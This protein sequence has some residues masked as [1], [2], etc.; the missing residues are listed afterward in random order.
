MSTTSRPR[1]SCPKHRA[2]APRHAAPAKPSYLGRFV[3][4]LVL[5]AA[6]VLGP[7]AVHH[8]LDQPSEPTCLATSAPALELCKE[9]QYR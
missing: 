4:G 7:L 1:T 9:N 8:Y 5:A 6:F 3:A 2:S